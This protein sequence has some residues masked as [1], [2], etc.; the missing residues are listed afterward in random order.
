MGTTGSKGDTGST[1]PKG[2][3]GQQGIQGP[4]GDTGQQGIQG[5]KGDTGKDGVLSLSS[6][7]GEQ[8]TQL[9]DK[10]T[11][12]NRAKGPKGD[13][14]DTGTQG[15]QGPKGD[16]PDL[17]LY[18]KL[19]MPT[20]VG[21]TTI[22]GAEDTK[23]PTKNTY[24]EFIIQS[25]AA[26]NSDFEISHEQGGVGTR[27][28]R[29]NPMNYNPGRIGVGYARNATIP[30]KFA[31]NGDIG[32]A[33]G[34]VSGDWKISTS[35]DNLCMKNGAN[36]EF[37]INKYGEPLNKYLITFPWIATPDQGKKQCIDISK[38]GQDRPT[39]ECNPNDTKQHFY[40]EEGGKIKSA[41][42]ASYKDK[43]LQYTNNK[44]NVVSCNYSNVDTA[45]NEQIFGSWQ[46]RI[47]PYVG[48]VDNGCFDRFN[49]NNAANCD[50]NENINKAAQL[51]TKVKI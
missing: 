16:A 41:D 36:P 17:S 31:V 15:I 11:Q 35:G 50:M 43:C 47:R 2:D 45:Y 27:N 7:T 19:N 44:Y 34:F 21:G 5:P 29:I 30:A 46:G 42:I 9:I 32:A 13:K 48:N 24:P 22:R 23:D 20:F 39:S 1:G 51:Y 6:L 8:M 4:K 18:A 12:D 10:I 40:F 26:T 3:I 37:C 49:S 33:G 38:I 28:I 14:G 25:S